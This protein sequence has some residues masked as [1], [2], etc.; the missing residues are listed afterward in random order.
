M[1]R[2]IDGYA[3]RIK[4]TLATAIMPSVEDEEKFAQYLLGILLN[5]VTDDEL[6]KAIGVAYQTW[7]GMY[8]EKLQFTRERVVCQ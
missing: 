7:E 1:E 5:Y 3:N 6:S 8:P 2:E 4:F